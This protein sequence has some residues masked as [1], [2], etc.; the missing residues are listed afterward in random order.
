MNEKKV[1]KIIEDISSGLKK[2]PTVNLIK[3]K[4]WTSSIKKF[5]E[6]VADEN[7]LQY[8]HTKKEDKKREWLYDSIMFDLND[9]PEGGINSK[10]LNE[11]YL[12]AEYE[13]LSDEDSIQEDFEK[14]LVAKSPI[15]LMIYRVSKE[16]KKARADFLKRIIN[17]SKMTN[18][19]EKY[20]LAAWITRERYVSIEMYQ[21]TTEEIY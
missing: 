13:W 4:C 7:T 1:K 11:V 9:D 8:T 17:S 10:M 14:L 5:L 20:I 12:C 21:K 6:K 18:A 3:R 15:K 16:E 2:I 19:A